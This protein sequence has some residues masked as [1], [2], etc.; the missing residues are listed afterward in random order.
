MTYLEDWK[1]LD[2]EQ[3]KRIVGLMHRQAIKAKSDVLFFKVRTNRTSE[4]VYKR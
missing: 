4:I 2:P 3:L 1:S